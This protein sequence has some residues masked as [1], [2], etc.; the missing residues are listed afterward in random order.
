[1]Y[2]CSSGARSAARNTA[3][4]N[5]TRQWYLA[6]CALFLSDFIWP[7]EFPRLILTLFSCFYFFP[8]HLQW[9]KKCPGLHK[10]SWSELSKRIFPD[11]PSSVYWGKIYFEGKLF[12]KML[13]VC[14]NKLHTLLSAECRT[15]FNV[16]LDLPLWSFYFWLIRKRPLVSKQHEV[17][18]KDRNMGS[19]YNSDNHCN[20]VNSGGVAASEYFISIRSTQSQQKNVMFH[21]VLVLVSLEQLRPVKPGAL[22][23]IWRCPSCRF[24]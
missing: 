12:W 14:T 22:T 2:Y 10:T 6:V 18:N 8:T 20:N 1:M 21:I 23:L 4:T 13:S 16:S 3:L 17:A 9:K 15:S 5:W 19:P 24:L 7:P 11:F